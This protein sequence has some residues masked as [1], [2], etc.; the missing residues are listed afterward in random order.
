MIWTFSEDTVDGWKNL[1]FAPQHSLAPQLPTQTQP[2]M[3]PETILSQV[4]YSIKTENFS[5]L[6][7]AL[8][9]LANMDRLARQHP[10][11]GEKS[12]LPKNKYNLFL[13]FLLFIDE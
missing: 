3:S 7:A 1:G 8:V 9:I 11:Y 6:Q 10:I 12:V 5:P 2:F 4:G 13:S